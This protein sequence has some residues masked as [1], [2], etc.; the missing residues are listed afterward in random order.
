L[1]ESLRANPVSVPASG[2][3]G[4]DVITESDVKFEVKESLYCPMQKFP[5]LAAELAE[6]AKGSGYLLAKIK[7]SRLEHYD[8]PQRCKDDGPFSPACQEPG[9]WQDEDPPAVYCADADSISGMTKE[10]FKR[11]ADELINTSAVCGPTFSETRMPC[12]GWN[13]RPKW[14][15]AGEIPPQCK[16]ETDAAEY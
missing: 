3:R 1:L 6:L 5:L 4:P 9:G 7:Q 11:Y 13:V 12:V 2:S 16:S 10:S 14:Q 15:Y 8:P